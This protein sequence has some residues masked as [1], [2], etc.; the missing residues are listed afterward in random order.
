MRE[1][2]VITI[3]FYAFG[4]QK[5]ENKHWILDLNHLHGEQFHDR[6]TVLYVGC[7]IKAD[8][9]FSTNPRD[10]LL[11]TVRVKH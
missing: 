9:I 5:K 7:L 2:A 10:H 6:A 1:L 4:T 11:M 8:H 3:R